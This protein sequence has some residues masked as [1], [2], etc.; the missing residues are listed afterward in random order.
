M[1]DFTFKEVPP[2]VDV[3]LFCFVLPTGEPVDVCVINTLTAFEETKNHFPTHNQCFCVYLRPDNEMALTLGAYSDESLN[4]RIEDYLT[5]ER[6]RY[7]ANLTS[8]DSELVKEFEHEH[9]D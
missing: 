9:T 4:K 7:I 6:L 3:H 5:A 2:D 8:P 1:T